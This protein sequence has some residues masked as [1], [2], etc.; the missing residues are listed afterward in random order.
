MVRA[1]SE[2]EQEP[3]A[4]PR[5]GIVCDR[6]VIGCEENKSVRIGKRTGSDLGLYREKVTHTSLALPWHQAWHT[7]PKPKM[8]S[9]L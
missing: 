8:R 7:R 9:I 5:T 2:E 3:V 4:E 1:G 6:V